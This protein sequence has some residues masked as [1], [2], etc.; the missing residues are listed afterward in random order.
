MVSGNG[1]KL[2]NNRRATKSG[3]LSGLCVTTV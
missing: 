1:D 2:C 3:I